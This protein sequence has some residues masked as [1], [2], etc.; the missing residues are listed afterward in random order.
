[1]RDLRK[2]M[3]TKVVVDRFFDS[4]R[5]K[6]IQDISEIYDESIAI[7]QSVGEINQTKS[8]NIPHL[9]AMLSLEEL[10]HTP[11]SYCIDGN[12]AAVQCRVHM[13]VPSGKTYDFPISIFFTVENSRITRIEEYV[14]SGVVSKLVEEMA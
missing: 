11:T 3:N 7:W 1:M 14:D 12:R 8:E 9:E 10:W 5:N 4:I 2:A 13:K 6:K